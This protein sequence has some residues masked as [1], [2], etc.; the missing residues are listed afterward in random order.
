MIRVGGLKLPLSYTEEDLRAA[1]VKKLG[2]SPK[3]VGA[4]S[5]F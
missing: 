4:C 2:V 1:V 3:R 5:L